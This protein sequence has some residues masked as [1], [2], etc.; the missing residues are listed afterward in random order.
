MVSGKARKAWRS[1][2]KPGKAR[3]KETE[4][5]P[6]LTL[7]ATSI[8]AMNPPLDHPPL[9]PLV[10]LVVGVGVKRGVVVVV[11]KGVLRPFTGVLVRESH[12][13]S[14]Y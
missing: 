13:V 11:V 4:G 6:G 5:Q 9:S 10:Y 12:I 1:A 7:P 3:E 14:S 2:G 8:L